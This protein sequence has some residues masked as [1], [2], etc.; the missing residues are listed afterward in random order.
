MKVHLFI[1][2]SQKMLLSTNFKPKKTTRNEFSYGYRAAASGS[3]SITSGLAE[4]TNH[5]IPGTEST[6]EFRLEQL[7]TNTIWT[8]G[9]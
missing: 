5:V 2:V 4:S 9:I 8:I 7:K 6:E 3:V 1:F